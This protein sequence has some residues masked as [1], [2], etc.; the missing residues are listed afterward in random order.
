MMRSPI[1]FSDCNSLQEIRAA[2][3]KAKVIEIEL[4]S[5]SSGTKKIN[6][7]EIG[8]K[9]VPVSKIAQK[10]FEF[11]PLMKTWDQKELKLYFEV[12]KKFKNMLPERPVETSRWGQ[13]SELFWN[14]YTP[15]WGNLPCCRCSKSFYER[16]IIEEAEMGL[17][18]YNEWHNDIATV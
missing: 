12:A 6:I 1:S 17:E 14:C 11:R 2:L 8:S 4:T 10:I 15:I 9:Q 5:R 16:A 7:I 18:G 3:E 13:I